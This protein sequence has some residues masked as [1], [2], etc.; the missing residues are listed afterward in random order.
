MR[1]PVTGPVGA[2]APSPVL[3]GTFGI[4]ATF[5]VGGDLASTYLAISAGG[6]EANPFGRALL[7]QYGFAGATGL[8]LLTTVLVGVHWVL[9]LS[10]LEWVSPRER[11]TRRR[12]ATELAHPVLLAMLGASLTVQNLHV[13]FLLR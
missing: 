2:W 7:D 9:T 1:S 8:K 13:Y 11:T 4:A 12:L 10:V 3:L 5:R 6:V